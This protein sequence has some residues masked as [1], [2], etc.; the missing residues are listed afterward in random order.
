MKRILAIAG[1]M[2]IVLLFLVPAALA[3]EPM[4]QTGRVV[5]STQ[6]DITI[7]AGEQADVVLVINGTATIAG[8]VNTVVAVDGAANLTGAR[9][10]T[11]IAVRSPVTLGDGAVVQGDVMTLD[12]LVQQSGDARVLGEISDMQASLIGL[13]AVLAPALILLWIGFGLAVVV[14]G[15]LLAGVAGR[16]VRAAEGLISHEPGMTL[17]AG[18]LGLVV[19]PIVAFLLIVTVV[20]APLGV[21][22]LI[23]LWPLIAFAG[24]LVAG[25][26]IGDWVL[27]RMQPTVVRERPLLAAVIG[28]LVLQ[29]LALVPVLGI[30]AMIA[31]L[32]GFGAVLLLAWRTLRSGTAP[33]ATVAG[34]APAPMAS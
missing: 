31:S 11:V 15:L 30:V 20:G 6:G 16:Q 22:I 4:P 10:E 34:T 9:V 3:A 8:E 18:I 17:V 19:F 2:L 1:A 14:A 13:G 21:G 7:P 24:Y 26:W 32:F 12:S 5:I 25:I 29:A 27:H 33:Q 23:A 28:I